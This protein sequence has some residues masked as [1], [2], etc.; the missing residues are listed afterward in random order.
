MLPL[1]AVVWGG[2][3]LGLNR[4]KNKVRRAACL[5]EFAQRMTGETNLVYLQV[6]LFGTGFAECGLWADL[7]RLAPSSANH[8][9]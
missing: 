3:N 8:R 2:Y 9:S 1:L 6:W 5:H 7:S 4:C